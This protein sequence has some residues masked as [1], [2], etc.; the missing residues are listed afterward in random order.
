MEVNCLRDRE[1]LLLYHALNG[2]TKFGRVVEANLQLEQRAFSTGAIAQPSSGP[3]PRSPAAESQ[4]DLVPEYSRIRER[5][6]LASCT[7]HIRT[8]CIQTRV[9]VPTTLPRCMK[10]STGGKVVAMSNAV[11]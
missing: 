3:H 4:A 2:A 7:A 5:L 1:L 9:E 6:V 8:I 10:S 11:F